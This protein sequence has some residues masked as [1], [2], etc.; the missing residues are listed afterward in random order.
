MNRTL[1]IIFASILL[2]L[3]AIRLFSCSSDSDTPT[4][5]DDPTGPD[6]PENAL[7]LPEA[8]AAAMDS[9]GAL[10]LGLLDSL[11]PMAARHALV[12][13]LSGKGGAISWAGLSSDSTTISIEFSDGAIALLNTNELTFPTSSTSRSAGTTAPGRDQQR[14]RATRIAKSLRQAIDCGD[15]IMPA[16]HKVSIVNMAGG[17]N[18]LTHD[19]IENIEQSLIYMGWEDADIDVNSRLSY[20]DMSFVPD[21]MFNQQGHGIVLYVGH[22]GVFTEPDGLEHYRLQ[23]FLGHAFLVGHVSNQSAKIQRAIMR[24]G[25]PVPG[26]NTSCPRICDLVG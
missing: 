15:I 5:S 13:E 18:P 6:W 19:F 12:D 2:I 9:A 17:T 20:D 22:G 8:D 7:A 14:T 24:I 4:G 10:Y 3:F 11:D 26:Y 1:I 16:S 23:C 21:D 25:L